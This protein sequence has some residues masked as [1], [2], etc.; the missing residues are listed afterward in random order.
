MVADNNDELK[1]QFEVGFF[2]VYRHKLLFFWLLSGLMI[3]FVNRLTFPVFFSPSTDTNYH[4]LVANY[5]DELNTN[6]WLEWW[7]FFLIGWHF[8][9]FL[10]FSAV[11]RHSHFTLF[12][13]P[14]N[15]IKVI[16]KLVKFSR[17]ICFYIF[18]NI[19]PFSQLF[20]LFTY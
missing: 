11:C 8:L 12:I 16:A 2:A 9:D 3:F 15:I 1:L 5:N 7:H 4:V 14:Y 17:T 13:L 18:L 6:Y 19:V 20:K 10:F